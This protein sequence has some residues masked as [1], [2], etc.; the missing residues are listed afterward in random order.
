MLATH[1]PVF[2]ETIMFEL[3]ESSRKSGLISDCVNS[4]KYNFRFRN[5]VFEHNRIILH[6]S[7]VYRKGG[8]SL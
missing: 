1:N 4:N 8:Y 7:D 3:I 5:P 2:E 6:N